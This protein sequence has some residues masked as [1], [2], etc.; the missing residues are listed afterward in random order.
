MKIVINDEFLKALVETLC[1]V[2]NYILWQTYFK[3]L[4]LLYIAVSFENKEVKTGNKLIFKK[5]ILKLVLN[6]V[7]LKALLETLYTLYNNVLWHTNF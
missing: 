4:N 5:S 7:L 2:H 3:N 6:N 1:T